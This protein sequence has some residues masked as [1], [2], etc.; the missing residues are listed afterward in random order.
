MPTLRIILDGDG[1]W[2]DAS[3]AEHGEQLQ[4]AVPS[5]ALLPGGMT[6]G[7]AS[8]GIRIDLP[9]GR[10]VVAQTSLALFR[11]AVAAFNGREQYIAEQ[12]KRGGSA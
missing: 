12:A 8:V 11:A 6:S 1:C 10:F 3:D 5:V 7:R 2:P 9:D 4:H